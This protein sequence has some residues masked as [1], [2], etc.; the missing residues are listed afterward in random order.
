MRRD[1]VLHPSGWRRRV[2][3]QPGSL[4]PQD[5]LGAMHQSL[6]T[7]CQTWSKSRSKQWSDTL[8]QSDWS[9]AWPPIQC[10]CTRITQAQDDASDFW[11][12]LT[13]FLTRQGDSPK[14]HRL[15]KSFGPTL[16]FENTDA[17]RWTAFV[18]SAWFRYPSR[19]LDHTRPPDH[20]STVTWW[21]S[22]ALRTLR[23]EETRRFFF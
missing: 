12:S 22:V 1:L 5:E 18:H 14:V 17:W 13:I 8:E 4:E 19:L 16:S 20:V 21:A 6:A 9:R 2:G 15:Q 10:S 7:R 3:H 11:E 23:P